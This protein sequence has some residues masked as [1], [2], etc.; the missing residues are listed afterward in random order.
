MIEK[1]S[2]GGVG[3]ILVKL[4]TVYKTATGIK[5]LNGQE[6]VLGDPDYAKERHANTSGVVIQVPVSYGKHPIGSERVGFPAYG[7]SRFPNDTDVEIK[8]VFYARP[9]NKVKFR[10]DISPEIQVGDVVYFQWNAVFDKRNLIA[11]SKDKKSFIFKVPVDIVYCCVREGKIIPIGGHV[12]IDPI[13]E[14]WE[15]IY[16]PTYFPFIDHKTGKQAVRPK[17]DWIQIR[18]APKQIDRQGII[19]HIGTPLKGDRCALEVGMKVLY[20]PNLKNLLDV[21]GEKY[22]IMRQ[23]QILCYQP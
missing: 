21:E 3:H 6:L 15:S 1:Y 7:P 18:T 11:Q 5:G 14:S 2:R 17:K 23:N 4:D 20:K 12:L 9:R 8:D 16:K 19:K 22:F 10:N 13:M